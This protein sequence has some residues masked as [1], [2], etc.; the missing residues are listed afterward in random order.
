MSITVQWDNDEKTVIRYD[1]SD[2]WTWD[3]FRQAVEQ[4]HAM[5]DTVSHTVDAIANL[6]NGNFLPS[7]SLWQ[8][9][10]VASRSHPRAGM[11]V[12]VKGSYMMQSLYGLFRSLYG[13]M[14]FY[15]NI[16]FAPTLEAARALLEAE[17]EKP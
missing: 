16:H 5:I 14:G 7:G 4:I 10:N 12:I 3:E 9:R 13:K 15:V 2:N 17:R 1:V 8:A 11:T 6:E